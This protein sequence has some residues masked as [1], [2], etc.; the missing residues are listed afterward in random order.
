ML[1]AH[2]DNR[3]NN[4][5]IITSCIIAINCSNVNMYA[6]VCMLVANIK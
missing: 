1:H 4:N 6:Y 2:S 5:N 3:N